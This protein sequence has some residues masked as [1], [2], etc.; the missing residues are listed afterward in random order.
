MSTHIAPA[1]EDEALSV[2][3]ARN[4][5]AEAARRGYT[6]AQLGEALGINRVGITQRYGFH[7][8]WTVDEV[9]RAA[10]VFK[11]APAVLLAR[12]EGFEP[13]TFWF[14]ADEGDE[15]IDAEVVDLDSRRV[16]VS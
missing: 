12:P 5:R 2:V 1:V 9:E 4:I 14:G 16:M 11:V 8:P 3:V 13:P 10:R 15:G 7:T 6:Q